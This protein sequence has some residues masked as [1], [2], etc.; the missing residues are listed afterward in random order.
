MDISKTG[1]ISCA[2]C[3]KSLTN[4]RRLVLTLLQ[5]LSKHVPMLVQCFLEEH[6]SPPPIASP[7]ASAVLA[8]APSTTDKLLEIFTVSLLQQHQQQK[9]HQHQHQQLAAPIPPI[10]NMP[11]PPIPS[12]P[13]SPEKPQH[14]YISLEEFCTFYQITPHFE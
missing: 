8:P 7:S 4:A 11:S 6:S 13:Q 2:N 3:N 14:R 10:I 9:Q 12:A 1:A 5:S